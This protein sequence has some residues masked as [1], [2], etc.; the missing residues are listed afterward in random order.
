MK[1]IHRWL[2][3]SGLLAL[4]PALPAAAQQAAP[5]VIKFSHVTTS[6]TP[7]GKGAD[8]FR[9]L[10]EERTQGRVRVEVYPNST[11]YKETGFDPNR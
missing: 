5:I 3:L 2:T 8:Q 6:D 10:A 7:K 1:G 11:L 4:L 9:K